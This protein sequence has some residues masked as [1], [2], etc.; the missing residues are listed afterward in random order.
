MFDVT[1]K[2]LDELQGLCDAATA[3]VQAT[4]CVAWIVVPVPCDEWVQTGEGEQDGYVET[5]QVAEQQKIADF[6]TP[7]DA[8]FYAAACNA[9]PGLV[10]EVK[11]LRERVEIARN[12]WDE[13]TTAHRT[14][15]MVMAIDGALM[16][17]V[18]EWDAEDRL[19]WL[20]VERQKREGGSC[21][22]G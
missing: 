18:V 15:K 14:G 13:R 20:E 17:A 5:T 8:A 10:A 22:T 19:L 2:A 12:W 16:H 7:E 4:D 3:D 21:S 11:R 9:V 6:G 1:D